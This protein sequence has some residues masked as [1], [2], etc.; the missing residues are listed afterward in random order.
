MILSFIRRNIERTTYI[1]VCQLET[2][3]RADNANEKKLIV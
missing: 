3:V 2:T 1:Y